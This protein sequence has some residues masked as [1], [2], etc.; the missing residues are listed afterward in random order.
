M[1]GDEIKS[2]LYEA[3]NEEILP[4]QF[5]RIEVLYFAVTAI[6][7][8]LLII[9]IIS[10]V[11]T[12]LEMRR[13]FFMRFYSWVDMLFI[14]LNLSVQVMS[15]SDVSSYREWTWIIFRS[16]QKIMRLFMVA[17]T[18]LLFAKFSYFLSLIDEV[19]PVI[20]I[21]TQILIDIKYFLVVLFLQGLALSVS[22]YYI[23]QNQVE[24][25][26]L[27]QDEL[28]ELP[29]KTLTGSFW[30]IWEVILGSV[31]PSMYQ[32][33]KG[34]QSFYL[35]LLICISAFMMLVHLLNMLI[36]IMGN[37]FGTDTS[38]IPNHDS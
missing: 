20:D 10:L 36:A 28:D 25:D 15:M 19:A 34:T 32:M 26:A 31:D 33:G 14:I 1:L 22:F 38:G 5:K 27:S 35:H 23:A 24:F 21:I 6:N 12:Y 37:T 16:N 7:I 30:Y 3:R 17:C 2:N 29:Y 13:E 4:E 18:M 9:I 8:S 11:F